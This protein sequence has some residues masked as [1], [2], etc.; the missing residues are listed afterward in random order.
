[1]PQLTLF[2]SGVLLMTSLII[3]FIAPSI[4]GTAY[5]G[6]LAISSAVA[7][8]GFYGVIWWK[9]P[10]WKYVFIAFGAMNAMFTLL[11]G[12]GWAVLTIL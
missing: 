3:G 7:A 12:F 9:A 5:L 11:Y 4:D 6:L 10:P 1:M 8:I 2:Q